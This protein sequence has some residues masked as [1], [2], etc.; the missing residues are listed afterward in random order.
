[1]TDPG[2]NTECNPIDGYT[3]IQSCN[4]PY[5]QCGWYWDYTEYTSNIFNQKIYSC[6]FFSIQ[7]IEHSELILGHDQLFFYRKIDFKKL[8]FLPGLLIPGQSVVMVIYITR[9]HH[10]G[11]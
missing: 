4:I 5:D 3:E 8:I 2:I 6:T 1:M 11:Y 9:K 10:S 7:N